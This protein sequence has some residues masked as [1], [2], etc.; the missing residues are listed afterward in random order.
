MNAVFERN[1]KDGDGKISPQEYPRGRERFAR[2]DKDSD[3]FIDQADTEKSGWTCGRRGGG[4]KAPQEGALAP[5]FAL[6]TL[7]PRVPAKGRPRERDAKEAP[8]YDTV[9]LSSFRGKRPA[10]L[11][12]GSYT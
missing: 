12:F 7:L 4:R 11:I 5:D 10:A 9:E 1:D 3:G 6:G 2:L 8:V